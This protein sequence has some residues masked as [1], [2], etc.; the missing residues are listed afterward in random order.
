[1]A[2]VIKNNRKTFWLDAEGDPVPLKFIPQQDQDKDA[3]IESL[4]KSALLHHQ[5]LVEFKATALDM[6]DAYL[7]SV[8]DS[9]H[10]NWKGN[11]TIYNFTGD[12]AIEIKISNK[13]AFDERL[14]IA[15]QKI[16]AYLISL[17]KNAGKEIVALITK[18][19]KVDAKGNVDVK[20]II[21]LKQHK[22]DHPLWIEAM[23]II[24]E[25]LRVEGTRRYIVFK[26]KDASGAWISITLNFSA[27]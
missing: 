2:Q 19:F 24:D 4:N 11:A 9:Y 25:A 21:S 22:F 8:A 1:M 3:L 13:L 15:K 7:Q 16:D 10:E 5:S 20:Q 18:A 14:N 12:K 17:V 26:Q 23:A 6:I 27:I